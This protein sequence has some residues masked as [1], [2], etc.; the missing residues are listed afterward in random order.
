MTTSAAAATRFAPEFRL[1]LDGAP[2]PAALRAAITG[3]T[4]TSAL[5]GA[6]RVDLAIANHGRRWLDHRLL[7]LGASVRLRIGYAPD[8]LTQVFVGEV[9]STS[10][11]FPSSGVPTMSVAAHDRMDQLQR[12]TKLRSLG[13]AI[14]KVGN[15]PIPD[16]GVAQ[17][18]AAENQL[19]PFVAPV[20]AALSAVL[21]GA[22]LLAS[23][24]DMGALQ[25]AIRRQ[26]NEDDLAFLRRIARENGWEMLID[27]S[28]AG[29]GNTLRF[30]SPLDQLAP[31]LTLAYGRSML[32]F[33]PRITNVGQVASVTGF[34]WVDRIKTRFR[35][36]LGWDWDNMS[37]TLDVSPSVEGLASGPSG[38]QLAGTGFILSGPLTLASAPRRIVSELVPKL[39]NRLTGSG[40][41]VGDAR[42]LA[43]RV[44]RLEGLGTQFSG[45]Y[46]V[47]Q[48]TH[49]ID[50]GGYRT[51]FECR[52]EI[53]FGSIPAPQQGVAPIRAVGA[54]TV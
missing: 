44:V 28:T 10:A 14:P 42:L 25:K 48:A 9:V 51:S 43:G 30:M 15:F 27:H 19:I 13:F 29:G 46:R 3:V 36:T 32:D 34:V 54:H 7:R 45:L 26:T 21:G 35:V 47:T 40:S 39:N 37:L 8:A 12:G 16:V 6:Q 4:F 49:T 17:L 22:E 11:A 2:I 41:A 31:D 53:W 38:G 24:A 5:E 50:G 33:T 52:K 1:E 20:G 23:G 18:V